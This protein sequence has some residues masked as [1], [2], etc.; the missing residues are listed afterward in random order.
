MQ[1]YPLICLIGT[2]LVLCMR[3]KGFEVQNPYEFEL[4]PP[5]VSLFNDFKKEVDEEPSEF[6]MFAYIWRRRVVVISNTG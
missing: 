3:I 2:K 1:I 6:D 5:Y 4:D